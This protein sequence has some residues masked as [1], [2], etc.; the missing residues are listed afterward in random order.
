MANSEPVGCRRFCHC[1][2]AE[3]L[4]YTAFLLLMGFGYVMALSYLYMVHQGHD[5]K[6]GLSIEDIAE[7]YYGNRSGTRLEAAI[8]GPM[9]GYIDRESRHHIVA[10]LKGG[11]DRAS[12]DE[13]VFPILEQRCLGCHGGSSSLADLSSVEGVQLVAQVDTGVSVLSLLRI[14]HIHLFGVGLVLLS[15]GMIFRRASLAGWLKST[16]LVLPFVAILA[17]VLAWFMTHWDPH[18]ALTVVAAGAVLGLCL[19]AQILI[20]LYQIWFARADT[21]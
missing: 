19:G 17:D 15:V 5:G 9:S 7:N 1:E 3:K 10:W 6:P 11:A 21:T 20:S 8:R 16:L 18:Y 14:S 13:Q 4:F 2:P 12:F